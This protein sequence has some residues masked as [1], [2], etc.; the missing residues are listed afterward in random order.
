MK[1]SLTAAMAICAALGAASLISGTASARGY[2]PG[3]SWSES[4][5]DANT[6][7]GQLTATC[8]DDRGRSRN[9]S[10]SLGGCDEFENQNGNL[11]CASYG[12]NGRGDGNGNG[13]GRGGNQDRLP[14]GAWD[15]SCRDASVRGDTLYA[16]CQTTQGRFRD[17]SLNLRGCSNVENND[18]RLVCTQ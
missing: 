1:K 10:A 15:A 2:M 17:S 7:R 3:G 8:R 5:W 12:G 6:S 14:A 16:T 13:Y 18:G 9:T 4:C 11:V